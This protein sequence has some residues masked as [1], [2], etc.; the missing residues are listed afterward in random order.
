M[1]P[2]TETLDICLPYALHVVYGGSDFRPE[3]RTEVVVGLATGIME[4]SA[5][6]RLPILADAL[7][8]AGCDNVDIL[9]HCRTQGVHFRGCWAVDLVLDQE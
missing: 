2:D 4:D 6:E 9:N 8:E 3:W 1:E 7:E 5:Y